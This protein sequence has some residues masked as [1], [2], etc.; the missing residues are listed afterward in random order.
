MPDLLGPKIHAA[1]RHRA[2]DA[3]RLGRP[4]RAW[5]PNCGMGAP[6]Y[7]AGIALIEALGRRWRETAVIVY[8][9][10]TDPVALAHARVGHFRHGE[11]PWLSAKRSARFFAQEGT[12]LRARKPLRQVC[13]FAPPNPAAPAPFAQLDLVIETVDPLTG[14]LKATLG[15]P[16][17]AHPG[18]LGYN[19]RLRES[20]S[21]FDTLFSQAEDAVLVRDA[22]TDAIVEANESAERLYGWTVA[23]LLTMRGKDLI[24]PPSSVRRAVGERR[25]EARLRLPHHR[26]SDGRL[27]PAQTRTSF[28]MRESRPCVL[29]TVRDSTERMRARSAESG[30]VFIGEVVHELRSPVSVIQGFAETLRRGVRNPS[31]RAEFLKSIEGQTVRMA[32]LVDRLLD[33]SAAESGKRAAQPVSL[34]VAEKIWEIAAAFL[35]LAKRKGVTLKIDAPADLVMTADPADLPH[36][37]GNL[38][39][40]A[41]K[42]SPRG[43]CVSIRGRVE[44]D[45]AIVSIEDSG[46]G[47]PPAD[48]EKIFERFYRTDRTRAA[49]GTG[50]GLAIVRAIVKAN[51]GQVWTENASSGGAVFHVALPRAPMLKSH[52]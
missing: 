35:P 47:V 8:G 49:K 14:A 40:N 41:V 37:F 30:S 1:L 27:F 12:G 10:D 25:S 51:G 22:E 36:V 5:A 23:Q 50:L 43:G 39:D 29:W 15:A 4:L 33:L 26:R 11:L 44:G 6:A 31:D 28:I 18:V 46:P 13:H 17:A 38:L 42:F 34:P 20:E 7:A 3:V 9:T 52:A 24:A 45:R 19:A 2:Q 32:H 21:K 48:F 16:Q